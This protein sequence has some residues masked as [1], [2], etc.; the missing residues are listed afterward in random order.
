MHRPAMFVN[1][2]GRMIKT[3]PSGKPVSLA[4]IGAKRIKSVIGRQM[5]RAYSR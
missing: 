2:N 5:D 4:L 3:Y 1:L